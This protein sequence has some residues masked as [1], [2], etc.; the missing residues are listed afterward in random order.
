M[1]D[2]QK[3]INMASLTYTIKCKML[4]NIIFIYNTV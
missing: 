3:Q 1:N 2:H 4:I